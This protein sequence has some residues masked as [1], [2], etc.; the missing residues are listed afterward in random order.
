ML[1][2]DKFM[3]SEGLLELCS[4]S[5]LKHQ[6]TSP[7]SLQQ[8][9]QGKPPSSKLRRAG[10]MTIC[11]CFADSLELVGRQGGRPNKRRPS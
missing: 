1:E 6:K 11:A 8:L 2:V 7:G 5:S 10:S 3:C 9:I 4:V